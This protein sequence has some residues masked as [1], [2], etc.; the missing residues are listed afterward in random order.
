MLGI[1]RIVCTTTKDEK[2]AEEIAKALV[3]EKL[4]ACTNIFPV[5]SIYRWEG[6]IC[7][8]TEAAIFIKTKKRL[9]D[10]VIKTIK[11]LHSYKVPD[12]ISIPIEKG[13]ANFLRW[14]GESIK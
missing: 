2:K 8:E 3:E 4:V 7:E 11:E 6:K 10:E 1:Y 13:Y 14:I 5:R 9:V 12:I